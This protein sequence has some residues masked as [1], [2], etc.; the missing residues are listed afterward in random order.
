MRKILFVFLLCTTPFIGT[1][2]NYVVQMQS[3]SYLPI[4]TSK[5]QHDPGELIN[6]RY[7]RCIQ[8]YQIPSAEEKA[9]L[10]A[11][12]VRLLTYIPNNVYTASIAANT[13]LTKAGSKN[14]R[15]IFPL[16]TKYKTSNLLSGK[17]LPKW[18]LR[19]G[20][21]I[22]LTVTQQPDIPMTQ[23]TELLR[24]AGFEV[25][26]TLKDAKAHRIIAKTTQIA[27][28]ASLSYLTFIEPV[29]G[30]P[31]PED[32]YGATLHRSNAIATQYAS[33]LHF[34]GS[35]VNVALNDDGV[36]G[37]HIDYKGRLN[38][39]FITFNNGNHGDHCAGIIFGAGNRNPTARGMAFGANLLVY[40]VSNAFP[41]AYQAFDSIESAYN[42]RNVRIT[43]T[44]YGNGNNT[45]YTSLARLMDVQIN[46]MPELMHVFSSGNSGTSNFG[47]G[48]GA[49]WANV[50]GGHKQAK[51]VITVGNLDYLDVLASSSSRGPALD[52]RIKPDICALGTN[53][54]S[55]VDTDT[56]ELKS[57]TSMACPGVAG[58][59]AQLYQAYKTGHSGNNPTSALIK[60]V[61]LNTADDLGNPGPDYRFGWGRINARRA[62]GVIQNNQY[63]LDSVT[64]GT[65]KTHTIAVPANVAEVRL[66]VYWADYEGTAGAAKALVNDLNMSVTTPGATTVLPWVLNRTP[67]VAALNANAVQGIDTLNNVEQVTIPTPA[68][69][70]YTVNVAGFSVPQGPQKYYLVYEFVTNGVTLTYPIGGESIV[71]F[72]SEAIRWDALGS[73]GTFTLEYSTNNGGTWVNIANNISATQRFYNWNPPAVV[74]GKALVRVTRGA[75]TS[76]SSAPFSIIGLPSGLTVNWVCIDSMSVSYN[77]VTGANGYVVSVLGSKYMD[78]VGFS[79]TTTCVV[80][81]I[82]TLAGG[83]YSVHA[84]GT[85]SAQ[86]RRAY[87]Q[88]F[89]A[90]PFNCT[91]PIDLGIS[92]LVAPSGNTV[93]LCGGAPVTDTV[94]IKIVNNGLQ[95]ASAIKVNYSVNGGAPVTATYAGPLNGRDS[96]TYSF[97]QPI[98]FTSTGAYS[99]KAWIQFTNDLTPGNDTAMMLKYIVLPPTNTLPVSEDFETFAQGD[100]AAN[101][102]YGI[103]ALS[104]GWTNAANNVDDNID[105]RPNSGPTPTRA[106][107]A[108]TGPA[109]DFLPGTPAGKYLYLESDDCFASVA[110]LISPC[111]NLAGQAGPLLSFGAHLFGT[112]TGSL[113]VDVLADGVWNN[114]IMPALSGNKGDQWISY[115]TSLTAFTGKVVNIRFRGITGAT[116][117]SD[118]AL[119]KIAITNLPS[120]INE[121]ALQGT[122][123]VAPNP[124]KDVFGITLTNMKNAASLIVTD[125]NG[126]IIQQFNSQPQNGIIKTQVDLRNNAAGIYFLSIKD[127]NRVLNVKLVKL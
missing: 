52:G 3:G 48:A 89:R 29:E 79:T 78:S 58:T 76:Q 7:Y 30:D 110:H 72:T 81:N 66:M 124:S 98:T 90:A 34:D 19:S 45:G 100:T 55:T 36:I 65:T 9:S 23:V 117:E 113:H 32:T 69:G 84:V 22:E 125:V 26:H 8:F 47:Y 114:D 18:A 54:N 25:L 73:N 105:W 62:A 56:Y 92:G 43:S 61:V 37:P 53:V 83:W 107:S 77:A 121:T 112:G 99:I 2:Q 64:Q 63:R 70:N 82:G 49:G 126:R 6:G 97:A 120:G 80:K 123:L 74:T 27:K 1:A 109:Q 59:L 57:G 13:N 12:G 11:Q 95:P 60:A 118:I 17:K 31:V 96:V 39:Q 127:G 85:D 71:P 106:T 116:A 28:L 102:S 4:A 42:Q 38:G 15:T 104:N 67:T 40:G 14:I 93:L 10:E 35:G 50:T 5:L 122:M 75:S 94:K 24:Q 101:C 20:G 115:S 44:S 41:T 51:N 21:T 87:A 68:A 111:I 108:S 103:C 119:D 88:T 16:A 86:G 33:G 91:V 46:T